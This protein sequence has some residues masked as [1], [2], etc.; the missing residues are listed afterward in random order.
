[1]D[2]YCFICGTNSCKSR[3]GYEQWYKNHGT[4]LW[5]CLRCNRYIWRLERKV[6]KYDKQQ[7]DI[8]EISTR[9]C[10]CCG[11]VGI[12]KE[13]AYFNRPTDLI[14]CNACYNRLFLREKKRQNSIK[15]QSNKKRINL[16]GNQL[17]IGFIPRIGVCNWCRRIALVD[18]KRTSLHHDENRYDLKN[19]LRFT[20]EI[21]NIC[22]KIET[23][24]LKKL[25]IKPKLYF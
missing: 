11:K 14:L 25:G 18:C 17:F 24:R 3:L 21:C 16:C 22:H 15:I 23:W 4:D 19:P 8:K 7:R 1:M 10:Y 6:L 2:R 9:Q 13:R 12:P 5:L 20:I